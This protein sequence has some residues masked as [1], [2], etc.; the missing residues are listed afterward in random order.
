MALPNSYK[1]QCVKW[2][3]DHGWTLFPLNGKHPPKDFHWRLAKYDPFFAPAANFGVQ[4]GPDDLVVDIDPRNGGRIDLLP[5]ILPP[6]IKVITGSGGIHL[7]FKKP[8]SW[9]IKK[10]LREYRGID[11]LS[12]GCYVVGAGC[13]HSDTAKTY[14]FD[15]STTAQ[16]AA[17]PQ[18]LL[19]LIQKRAVTLEKGI[20]HVTDDEQTQ[21]RYIDYLKNAP[22][23]IEGASGDQFTFVTAA[24]GRDYGLSAD[25]TLELVLRYY[26]DRCIPPWSE[27][28]LESKVKNAYAYGSNAPGALAPAANFPKATVIEMQ[29]KTDGEAIIYTKE[30]IDRELAKFLQQNRNGGWKNNLNNA[31]N[32]FSVD[33]PN[34][35]LQGL[36]RFN[37]FSLNIEFTRPAPW[38]NSRRLAVW[39]EHDAIRCK[40]FISNHW[41]FEPPTAIIH[42]AALKAAMDSAYHPVKDYFLSLTWDGHKRVHRWMHDYLGVDD[43]EYTRAVGVKTLVA[44][45]NR[46]F[47]PGCKFDY[48][49]VLE[50]RQD[51]GKST[52]WKVMASK[53]W[54]GDTPIDITKEWSILKTLGKLMYEWAEMET[55]RKATNQAMKAFLSSDTDTVRLPYARVAKP[56]PRQGI[57]VGTFNPEA[58][59]D[60]GWLHDT[61]GNRRYWIVETS[62]AAP[63][64]VHALGAIRDQLWAEAVQMY[65]D[66]IP[67]YFEDAKIK[68][69]AEL[70]QAAR[71]G[72]DSWYDPIKSWLDAE[73]NRSRPVFTGDEIFKDCLGGNLMQYRRPEMT[74]IARV[75][76]ELGWRKGTHY[77]TIRKEAVNGYRR[78]VIE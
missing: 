19:D 58:D 51:T 66:G 38:H 30:E 73:G 69:M 21:Q 53:D 7:Y 40:H 64:N 27:K 41:K 13:L 18:A 33:F 16:T 26:N 37:E 31:A 60:I 74:R 45:V 67:I 54:F 1:D 56:I 76:M 14:K 78:P 25:T 28:E 5:I 47:Q 49:T 12:E 55:F 32:V 62:V 29:P 44:C 15:K 61:T 23:A 46:I 72:K 59:K 2:Y 77:H 70:E 68:A 34:P 50:G 43:N 71:L 75:M 57:F 4:L 65:Q 52:A 17:A 8:K 24:T 10:N 39:D 11:F 22:I 3:L 6:T 20:D 42:E 9:K 36:L 48:I 35:T 63:I